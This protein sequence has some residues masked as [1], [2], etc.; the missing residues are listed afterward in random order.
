MPNVRR[1]QHH[2]T[3]FAHT[4]LSLPDRA[5][6]A[7]RATTWLCACGQWEQVHRYVAGGTPLGTP[8]VW[9]ERLAQEQRRRT[10][11]AWEA[12]RQQRYLLARERRT[13]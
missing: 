8:E 2:W 1:H 7:E 3:V 4:L 11:E 5:G 10:P 13:L 9:E 12:A 6:G